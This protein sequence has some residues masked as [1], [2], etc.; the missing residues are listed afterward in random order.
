MDVVDV[1]AVGHKLATSGLAT[2]W[3][4]FSV[5]A[6]VVGSVVIVY[7]AFSH[8]RKAPGDDDGQEQSFS[9]VVAPV[10]AGFTLAAITGLATSNKP[11]QPW[12]DL[13][14]SYM[15]MATGFFLA[16]IQLSVGDLYRSHLKD[17]GT[18]RATLTF[19]GIALLVAA[20]IVLVAAVAAH[21]WVTV[22]L[23]VLGL[24]GVIPIGFQLYQY[25]QRPKGQA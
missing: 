17:W 11:G 18:G 2:F 20:L 3:A 21:W 12:S 1:V 19:I 24:G 16:S 6:V 5:V 15:I 22:A 23:V 8:P 10:L 25:L 14:L 13:A 4:G 9:A 7:R